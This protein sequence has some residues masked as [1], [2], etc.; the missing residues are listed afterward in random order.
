MK[1]NLTS[2]A[3]SADNFESIADSITASLSTMGYTLV[4]KN[5][6][7]IEFKEDLNRT[8]SRSDYYTMVSWGKFELAEKGSMTALKLSYQISIFYELIF[9]LAILIVALT[10]NYYALFLILVFVINLLFKI[11]YLKNN[12][13][14]DFLDEK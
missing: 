4:E 12:L 6:H 7:V 3:L 10:I 1:L 2:Q 11:N 8:S 13:I 14:A 9:L 5:D